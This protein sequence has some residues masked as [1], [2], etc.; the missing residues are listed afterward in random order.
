M[1]KQFQHDGE[2][3]K[4]HRMKEETAELINVEIRELP[5]W[6]RCI[7]SHS[8]FPEKWQ[9][10]LV[11]KKDLEIWQRIGSSSKGKTVDVLMKLFLWCWE[12]GEKTAFGPN[13]TSDS[14]ILDLNSQKGII[15][16]LISKAAPFSFLL[17]YSRS[18]ATY[19]NFS[20]GLLHEKLYPDTWSLNEV[21]FL[22]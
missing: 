9:N 8:I 5:I 10:R 21:L 11:L 14:S 22:A 1:A 19:A 17:C 18:I 3:T 2:N 6:R 15:T 16:I 20:Y 7:L 13:I 12:I 4:N